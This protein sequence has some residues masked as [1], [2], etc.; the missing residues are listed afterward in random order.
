MHHC[1]PRRSET[2]KSWSKGLIQTEYSSSSGVNLAAAPFALTDS[3]LG[4][5]EPLIATAGALEEHTGTHP[6]HL[7]LVGADR[8]P[9]PPVGTGDRG[10]SLGLVRAAGWAPVDTHGGAILADV[11]VPVGCG[12]PHPA[13]GALDP[14]RA[15]GVSLKLINSKVSDPVGPGHEF[16]GNGLGIV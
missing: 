6:V 1:T 14:V 4:V 11:A 15:P 7:G 5:P 9:C 13:I 3:L 8:G 2:Q 12:P 16:V 10:H